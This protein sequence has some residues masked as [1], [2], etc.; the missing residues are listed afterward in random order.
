MGYLNSQGVSVK[1]LRYSL[2]RI[3]AACILIS[4]R[5]RGHILLA[6]KAYRDYTDDD[7]DVY[8]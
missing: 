7:D 2:F 8:C 6:E 3:Q 4:V 1:A 5:H